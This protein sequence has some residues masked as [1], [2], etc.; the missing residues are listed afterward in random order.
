[1]MQPSV[2]A[3]SGQ[4]DNTTLSFNS[5]ARSTSNLCSFFKPSKLLKL[6]GQ[7]IPHPTRKRFVWCHQQ[8]MKSLLCPLFLYSCTSRKRKGAGSQKEK[9]PST[10]SIALLFSWF[11][12]TIFILVSHKNHLPTLTSFCHTQILVLCLITPINHLWTFYTSA[13][14]FLKWK[15]IQRSRQRH[16]TPLCNSIQILQCYFLS[17]ICIHPMLWLSPLLVVLHRE[18]ALDERSIMWCH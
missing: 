16:I 11:L 13:V 4:G 10:I 14:S 5:K 2:P 7:W 18:N 15:C 3:G 8:E 9:V 1:M 6:L 17:Q 12:F